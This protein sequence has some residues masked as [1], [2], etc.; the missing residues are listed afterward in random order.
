[1]KLK[2]KAFASI[3]SGIVGDGKLC[4]YDY[5]IFPVTKCPFYESELQ[6]LIL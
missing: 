5:V 4:L 6:F 3:K 1:M 2:T